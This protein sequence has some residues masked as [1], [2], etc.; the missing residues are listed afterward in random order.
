MRKAI[1]YLTAFDK[2]TIPQS[3]FIALLFSQEK[4]VSESYHE[5]R[6]PSRP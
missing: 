3:I 6:P 4:Q 5:V 2:N 1:S